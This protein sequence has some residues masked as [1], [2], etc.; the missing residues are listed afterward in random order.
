[1]VAKL[2]TAESVRRHNLALPA[3]AYSG[4]FEIT[5]GR[6]VHICEAAT[7]FINEIGDARHL[8]EVDLID[9]VAG[10]VVI[11]MQKRGEENDGNALR[12]VTVMIASI[13]DPLPIGGIV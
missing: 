3:F 6:V 8:I 5:H 12:R 7:G 10:T 11:R 13:I 1:M 9:L 2:I 4:T